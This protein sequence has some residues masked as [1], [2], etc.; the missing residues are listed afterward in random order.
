MDPVRTTLLVVLPSA[1]VAAV[2]F[3]VLRRVRRGAPGAGVVGPAVGLG[4]V[5]GFLAV[6]GLPKFP[7][8]EAWQWLPTIA[9]L[10]AVVGFVER[11]TKWTR[12][13]LRAALAV[14]AAWV[15]D[16][17]RSA[18]RVAGFVAAACLACFAFDGVARRAGP[19][20]SLAALLVVATAASATLVVS[21]T[22]T[23]GTA[24]GALA[25][26]TGACLVLAARTPGPAYGVATVGGAVVSSFLLNALLYSETPPVAAVLL[27]VA[28]FAAWAP[29]PD[30]EKKPLRAALVR[31]ALVAVV[32][33]AAV[34]VA[35]AKS[36]P[37]DY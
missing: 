22:M 34:A 32:A 8:L 19:R 15:T 2:V 1:V 31:T 28:P 4:F 13:P 16:L 33:G 30:A 25:A 36:P 14:F 37:L 18:L 9:V 3:L 11:G 35:V 6:A 26:A 7:P 20:T 17:D 12:W 24:C 23:L 5:A 29:V 21:G 10:A 27:A